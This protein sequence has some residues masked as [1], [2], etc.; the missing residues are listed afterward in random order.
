MA[1]NEIPRDYN[2]LVALGEDAADGAHTHGVAIGLKQNTEAAIRTDLT[3]LTTADTVQK[4]R[5]TAKL[6]A[7]AA[8]QT[9]DSNVKAFIALFLKLE[10]PRIG[11]QWGPLWQEAGFSSG[12]L[13]MPGNQ[14]DRFIMIGK[15]KGFLHDHPTYA[16]TDAARPALDVTEAAA[17]T[18]RAALD[19]ARQGV[20]EAAAQSGAATTAK[21]V[22][23]DALR[24]RL[25][26]LRDELGQIPLPDDSPLW[27]AFGFNRPADPATPGQPDGLALT[28]G[29]AGSGTLV[30]DWNPPR[31]A[32]NFRVS[33]QVAG[34]AQPK[35]FPLVSE[36]QTVLTA[37]P[38]GKLLTVTVAAHNPAGY[39]EES[40]PAT[41]TL[42]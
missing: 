16:V 27:Y 7:G 35:T 38:L 8:Q 33:V 11:D 39:G 13:A 10:S 9:A 5:A 14:D 41:T 30:V 28:H 37:L 2:S 20:N 19:T 21:G 29:A 31:R 15:L 25:G 18:L 12:S 24:R 32:D 26:G 6:A 17:E 3:A 42:T 4:A 36:D 40:S 23:L 22:A 1:S 34:E